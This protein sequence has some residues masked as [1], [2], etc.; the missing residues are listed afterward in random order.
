MAVIHK[1]NLH[2]AKNKWIACYIW[3]TPETMRSAIKHYLI[4][5]RCEVDTVAYFFAP[6]YHFDDETNRLLTRKLG[7][8]HLAE[9]NYGVGVVAHEIQHFLSHWQEQMGWDVT[10]DER[11]TISKLAGDLH[12]EFWNERFERY[13]D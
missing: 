11:E 9:E 13:N 7:E 8:I 10:G 3:P 2:P 12:N 5:S 1:W 6:E 4:N